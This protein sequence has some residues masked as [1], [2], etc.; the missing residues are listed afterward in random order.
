[1]N[2]KPYILLAE[3]DEV[4]STILTQRFKS[5]GIDIVLTKDGEQ[6]LKILKEKKP[7]ILILD[8][9]LPK[10]NGLKIL[11]KINKDPKLKN[12]P[13]IICSNL[14]D[15]ETIQKAKSLHAKEYLIKSDYS[16]DE[17]IEK[18]TSYL[19]KK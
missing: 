3:D 8:L 17:I 9:L 6:T 11:K 16:I 14:S 13:V 15:D 12:I 10:M 2:N 19:K 18:I 7:Q 5:E 4:L 1:M